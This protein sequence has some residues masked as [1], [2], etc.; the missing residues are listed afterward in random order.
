MTE[1]NFIS[2]EI[3]LLT[4]IMVETVHPEKIYLFGSFARGEQ[5]DESDYDFYLVMENENERPLNVKKKIRKAIWDYNDR[6]LDIIVS[7]SSNFKKRSDLPSL[8]RV[9]LKE[10]VLLYG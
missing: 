7:S 8:E 1:K 2:E 10:G 3:S 6:P 9:I 4:Q 5:T